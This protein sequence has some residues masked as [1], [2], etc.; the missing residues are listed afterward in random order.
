MPSQDRILIC[1][2]FSLRLCLYYRSSLIAYFQERLFRSSIVVDVITTF[3]NHEYIN[4]PYQVKLTDEELQQLQLSIDAQLRM[5]TIHLTTIRKALSVPLEPTIMSYRHYSKISLVTSNLQ[6]AAC[7]CHIIYRP[8]PSSRSVI[9]SA[10][11]PF[12]YLVSIS[13]VSQMS[14]HS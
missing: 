5:D 2:I 11:S 10:P 4:N 14:S 13:S 8:S 3:Y 1:C 7:L 6:Q 9:F 12:Q